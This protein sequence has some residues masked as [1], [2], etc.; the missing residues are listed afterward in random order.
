ML[1]EEDGHSSGTYSSAE[2]NRVM[3]HLTFF[4][5]QQEI[6][7]A[8]SSPIRKQEPRRL[9]SH[10]PADS[11]LKYVDHMATSGSG[12]D[13]SDAVFVIL[14]ASGAFESAPTLNDFPER[15]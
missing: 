15:S 8:S 11:R 10:V 4:T 14:P 6:S 7:E 1:T 5:V 13:I 2:A 12:F 3:S 9:L